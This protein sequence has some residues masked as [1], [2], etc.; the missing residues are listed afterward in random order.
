MILHTP[1]EG[2]WQNEPNMHRRSKAQITGSAVDREFRLVMLL[3][4]EL[5]SLAR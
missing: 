2:K 1:L 5:S 3:P 4:A